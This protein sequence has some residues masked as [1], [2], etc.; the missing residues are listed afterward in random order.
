MAELQQPT[1]KPT[2][3]Q[4]MWLWQHKKSI[5]IGIAVLLLLAAMSAIVWVYVLRPYFT[6]PAR[7][8][9]LVQTTTKAT[10]NVTAPGGLTSDPVV[11]MAEA[12]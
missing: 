11:I 8:A 2:P 10:A 12:P 7:T 1:P 5:S 9:A 6:E 3:L 4:T